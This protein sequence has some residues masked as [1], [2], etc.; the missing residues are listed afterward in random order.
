VQAFARRL[1]AVGILGFAATAVFADG[2][3]F[4]LA[5]GLQ[6][7]R[8]QWL[9]HWSAIALLPLTLAAVWQQAAPQGGKRRAIA[10]AAVALLGMP[11]GRYSAA[12]AAPLAMGLFLAWPSLDQ[13]VTPIWREL[14][15]WVLP[16]AVVIA[17]LRFLQSLWPRTTDADP[18]QYA[19]LLLHPL[20]MSILG[21]VATWMF[22][23]HGRKPV[24]ALGAVM[25]AVLLLG[26]GV[27]NWDRRD[28]TKKL[29]EDVAYD[30]NPFG[31][32]LEPG[33]QVYWYENL[34]AP[35]LLLH[36][37]SYWNGLQGA[38]LLFNRATA[39]AFHE[40]EQ[41]TQLLM[42]QGA[43]CQLLN[44]LERN[45]ERCQP[46][47]QLF[48][49]ICRHSDRVGYVVAP[50]RLEAP[51]LGTWYV[52]PAVPTDLPTVYRLYTCDTLLRID[53]SAPTDSGTH[54]PA[55]ERISSVPTARNP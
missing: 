2:L 5:T 17:Y 32:H 22:W 20:P 26:F 1:I 52:P 25:L 13:K 33:R 53:S 44:G 10:L 34:L 51:P 30:P 45:S 39:Q 3:R 36:H 55:A 11:A 31:V 19:M 4:V 8:V 49:N 43:L 27:A 50:F 38:G 41:V 35:W 47:T 21:L 18:Y 23:R 48:K 24:P 29:L 14:A 12:F 28:A 6:F 42:F 46:D 40:R 37:P 7:W 54:Q 15:F 9:A 16:T